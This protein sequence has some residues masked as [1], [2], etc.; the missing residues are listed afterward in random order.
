MPPEYLAFFDEFNHQRYY[1]AHDVLEKLWLP[2]R[3]SPNDAFYKGLIQ[4][5]GAFVHLQ[6]ERQAPAVA[7]LKLAQ[8]NLKAYPELHN[9]LDLR[10]VRELLQRWLNALEHGRFNPLRFGPPPRLNLK[11]SSSFLFSSAPPEG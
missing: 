3:K 9:G 11:S 5:A 6:N 10:S 4:V 2:S 1:E 8:L 7:L